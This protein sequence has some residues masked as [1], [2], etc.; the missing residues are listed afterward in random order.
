VVVW[1]I[2]LKGLDVLSYLRKPDWLTEWVTEWVSEKVTTREAIA[3]KNQLPTLSGSALKVYVVG[4]VASYPL[5]SQ[6]PTHV[7]VELGC[8]N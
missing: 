2:A 8:D 7:E 3:S 6:A 4:W 5:S 1:N